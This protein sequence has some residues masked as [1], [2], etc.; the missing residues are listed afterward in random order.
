MPMAETDCIVYTGSAHGGDAIVIDVAGTV[1]LDLVGTIVSGGDGGAVA[2]NFRNRGAAE[3]GNALLV[4]DASVTVYNGIFEGGTAGSVGGVIQSDGASMKVDGGAVTLYGGRFD[5]GILFSDGTSTLQLKDSFSNAAITVLSGSVSV[6]EWYDD[7]ISDVRV[8]DASISLKGALPFSLRGTYML[9][10]G[11]S[12]FEGG[13]LIESGG[14]LDVG[15]AAVTG[16]NIHVR[17]NSMV[18]VKKIIPIWEALR[19]RVH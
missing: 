16:S 1:E 14:L 3:G 15:F 4:N 17:S 6:L 7:Q 12:A 8:K 18:R 2:F 11:S 9:E 10:R 19:H 13:L 5:D